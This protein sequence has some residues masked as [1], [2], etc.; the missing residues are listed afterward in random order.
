[1]RVRIRD[2]KERFLQ[3]STKLL[4]DY[5]VAPFSRE[6][7]SLLRHSQL[8]KNALALEKNAQ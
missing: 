3:S 5:T 2:R 1:M 4:E 7:Q 8:G 6:R